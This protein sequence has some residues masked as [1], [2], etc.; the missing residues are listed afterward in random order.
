M[1]EF[2]KFIKSERGGRLLVTSDSYVY[3]L[4]KINNKTKI[5]SSFWRCRNSTTKKCKAA[6]TLYESADNTIKLN[7]HTHTHAPDSSAA[8]QLVSDLKDDCLKGTLGSTTALVNSKLKYTN[9]ATNRALPKVI[10]MRY[11]NY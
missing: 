4:G 1:V 5:H 10:L 9:T 6:V 8:L 3:R 7:Q 11:T 2:S